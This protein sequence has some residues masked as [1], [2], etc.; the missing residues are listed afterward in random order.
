[1]TV[2]INRH[3]VEVPEPVAD[4]AA[5]LKT[6][7]LDGAGTAVAVDDAVVPRAKGAPTPLVPDMKI[8]VISA[9]CGG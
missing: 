1:M 2:E 7:R 5:L 6:E 8:T 3:L 4:L 9:V